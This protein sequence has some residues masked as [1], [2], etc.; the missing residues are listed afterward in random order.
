MVGDRTQLDA[1]TDLH[2]AAGDMRPPALAL[3]MQLHPTVSFLIL[4]LF[5][6]FNAGIRMD[7]DTFGSGL[8][9]PV[10]LGVA[11]GLVIGKQIGI[12]LFSWAAVKSGRV[13]L[14]EGVGWPAIYGAACL[15]G[16]G[17]TMSLF[18]SDLAFDDEILVRPAKVGILC[19]S[20]AAAAWGAVVLARRLPRP[21]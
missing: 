21:G 5:A 8:A 15:G 14:P 13:S 17:F 18:I 12:A 1:I 7:A 10:G 2:R 9:H 4:P 20:V 19:A 16:I 6:L 11:L 3:E